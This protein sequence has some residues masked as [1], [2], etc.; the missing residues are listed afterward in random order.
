MGRLHNDANILV[1]GARVIGEGIALEM[2]DV[3]F[4]TAFEGGRHQIR[5]DKVD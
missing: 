4:K 3:F 1:L 5:L 2:L